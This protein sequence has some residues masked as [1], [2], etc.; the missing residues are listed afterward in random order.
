MKYTASIVGALMLAFTSSFIAA[1]TNVQQVSAALNDA[2]RRAVVE[3]AAKMLRE[4]YVFPDVG[5]QAARAIESALAGGGYNTLDQPAAFAQRLTE[6]LRAIAKD[7]HLAVRAP[8][9]APAGAPPPAP[10]RAEGGVARADIL[11]G[12]VGYIEVVGFPPPEAFNG[13]VNRAMAALQKTRALIVDVRRNGGGS[14]VT[15]SRLVSYF[16]RSGER[17]HINTFI[18]R[19]PG[20]ETFRSQDFWSEDTA[21][22][23]A[24]KPVIVLTSGRTF[25]GGEEFAYDMQVMDL[26]D[27]VGETTGGG[28]NPGGTVPLAAGLT[29]FIPNGRA[30]NPITGTNWEGVGVIPDVAVPSENALKVALEKLGVSAAGVEIDTLSQS[31]VFEPG[32]TRTTPQPGGEAAIR[33]IF[34]ELRNGQPNYALMSAAVAETT[35][36]QL[37]QLQSVIKPGNAVKSVSLSSLAPNGSDIYRVELATGEFECRIMLGADGKVEIFGIRPLN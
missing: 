17:V 22:S 36:K 30:R 26:A 4:R 20:T 10:V 2:N 9:A 7:K 16:L 14:P 18:N 28:A 13:P 23:Y 11:A 19:N 5:G 6:D 3:A 21:F 24:G 31:R 25:S 33:R 35:R 32:G 27:V 37:S 12:N 1:A 15:V 8:G 34:E 29:M